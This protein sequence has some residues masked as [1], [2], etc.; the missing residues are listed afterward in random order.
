MDADDT[1]ITFDEAKVSRPADEAEG[2]G[3]SALGGASLAAAAAS[4]ACFLF[5]LSCSWQFEHCQFFVLHFEHLESSNSI[6][7]DWRIQSK[8]E[9]LL[10]QQRTTRAAQTSPASGA[11][12]LRGARAL[13]LEVPE[14]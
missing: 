7:T 1:D 10:L 5:D 8:H 6:F 3:L 4:F 12:A 9:S 11:S 13:P 2:M 14:L